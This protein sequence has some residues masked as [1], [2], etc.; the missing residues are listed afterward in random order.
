MEDNVQDTT[1]FVQVD[2]DAFWAVQR[3]QHFYEVYALGSAAFYG[4][5]RC[6]LLRRYPHLQS[7][8]GVTL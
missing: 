4:K 7:D 1:W 3:P 6:G 2:G 5:I 8:L